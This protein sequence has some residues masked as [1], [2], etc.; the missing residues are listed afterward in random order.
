MP[1]PKRS[2]CRVLKLSDLDA[3]PIASAVPHLYG[4]VNFPA[5]RDG[6]DELSCVAAN[7]PKRSSIPA[8]SGLDV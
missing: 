3:E 7:M 2:V 8:L 6:Q 4:S 1:Y 5:R